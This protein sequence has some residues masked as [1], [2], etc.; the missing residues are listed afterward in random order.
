M[1]K[2]AH[3]K[4]AQK[5]R[6]MVDYL[7]GNMSEEA[8]AQFEERYFADDEMFER[9][10]IS[11]DELIDDYAQGRLSNSERERFERRF[12]NSRRRHEQVAFARVL[13]QNLSEPDVRPSSSQAETTS[14]AETA[15]RRRWLGS[16]TPWPLVWTT[17]AAAVLLIIGLGWLIIENRRLRAELSTIRADQSA[18]S[19]REQQLRHELDQLR[20][21]VPSNVA[22]P[23]PTLAP[24]PSPRSSPG[25]PLIPIE[26]FL[27]I[28]LEPRMRSSNDLPRATLAP[29]ARRLL[30]R[31][32]L[33]QEPQYHSYSAVLRSADDREIERRNGLR[34]QYKDDS[35]SIAA[36]FTATF[37]NEG[38]YNVTLFG[39]DGR[40]KLKE[41]R[42]KY[43]FLVV[44]Q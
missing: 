24:A 32:L 19:Q 4:D 8:E 36:E 38:E 41:I 35:Y 27:A 6:E 18:Q 21:Q 40:G 3:S 30:T 12:L 1:N 37:L 16:W 20:A 31:L 10:L 39:R 11:K 2:W 43:S 7:L 14:Q 17:T 26:S 9:F 15:L 29:S 28:D 22:S 23:S 34:P 5:D 33:D 42:K 44:R 25:A 13:S